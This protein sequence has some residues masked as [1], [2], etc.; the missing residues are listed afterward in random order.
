MDLVYL[1]IKGIFLSA[2]I[3]IVFFLIRYISNYIKW[4]KCQEI[5]DNLR[6]KEIFK[7]E[8]IVAKMPLYAPGLEVEFKNTPS[9]K[10]IKSEIVFT[11]NGIY[12]L[13]LRF[14]IFNKYPLLPI[15]F[16]KMLNKYSFEE[17]NNQ[18]LLIFELN[19][20]FKNLKLTIKFIG[21]IG[22]LKDFIKYFSKWESN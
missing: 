11:R 1:L 16:N 21:E 13:P 4:K 10:E 22:R 14:E 19:D 8:N 20:E 3:S 9:K 17:S 2:C 7:L 6:G 12:I 5:K 15:E 18:F